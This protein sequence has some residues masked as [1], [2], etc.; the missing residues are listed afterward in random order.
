[1]NY[2]SE[3]AKIPVWKTNNKLYL[4]AE[5]EIEANSSFI[6]NKMKE[7]K[8]W[9]NNFESNENKLIELKEKINEEK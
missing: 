6:L 8:L 4:H 1:M 7:V 3:L 9:L 2:A 5:D